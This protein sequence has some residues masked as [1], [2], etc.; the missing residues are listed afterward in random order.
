MTEVNALAID[1][2]DGL[3]VQASKKLVKPILKP[4][5]EF[6]PEELIFEELKCI[7]GGSLRYRQSRAA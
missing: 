1:S 7:S 6:F 4:N 5:Y 2:R 3:S